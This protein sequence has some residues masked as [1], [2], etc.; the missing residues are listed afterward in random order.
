[1]NVEHKKS[2]SGKGKTT[3][4]DENRPFTPKRWLWLGLVILLTILAFSPVFK[5][6]FTNWDDGG[7]VTENKYVHELSSQ[8]VKA[9][10]TEYFVS[11][12]QP[13]TMLSLAVDYSISGKEPWM[14]HISSLLLHLLNVILVYWLVFLLF[15]RFD[16]ALIAAALFGI[17]T[18]HVESVAWISDR[19]D[20][21]S[22]LFFMASL[23]SYIKYIGKPGVKYYFLAILFFILSLISKATAVALPVTLVACDYFLTGKILYRK[24]I[25]EKIPFFLLAIA[26]GVLAV[27]AQESSS[28]ISGNSDFA[29]YD[30]ILFACYGFTNYI[31]KLILPLNLSAIYPFPVRI[32]GSIPSSFWFYPIPVIAIIGGLIMAIRK[33]RTITFGILFFMINIF[34]VLQLIPIG[35]AIMADRYTYLPSAGFC[36][37]VGYAYYYLADKNRNMKPVFTAIIA[38][39]IFIL[40]LMTLDRT[41]AWKDSMTLWN[42]VI[43]KND[44]VTI[45]WINRGNIKFASGNY[46]GAI[47]DYDQSIMLKNDQSEAWLNRGTSRKELGDLKGALKD[48]DMAIRLNPDFDKSFYNRGGVK[49]D[50]N[51]FEGAIADYNEAILLNPN[52]AEAYSNRGNAKVN[53]ANSTTS[54][55]MVYGALADYNRAIE[56]KPDYTDAYSNRGIA[57]SILGDIAGAINDYDIT[58]TLNPNDALALFLRGMAK[59]GHGRKEEGCADLFKA[60]NLGFSQAG[61]QIQKLCNNL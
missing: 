54:T 53:L 23:I 5:N 7:Y 41:K 44:K 34:L 37:L 12:Y 25:L 19:K 2:I 18:L 29:F 15:R 39:Y 38:V 50:M 10:F 56:L 42:D 46:Q 49:M 48:Y 8:S 35:S 55:Q 6:E 43:S 59:A 1:M 32:N 13:L 21:L 17:H 14:F 20:L 51:D 61:E 27:Y 31:L 60:Y 36:I 3:D 28:S 26:A 47:T 22:T 11:N 4:R 45:A 58:L 24:I 40:S 9:F 16:I 30:R 52:Y 57:R 33:S